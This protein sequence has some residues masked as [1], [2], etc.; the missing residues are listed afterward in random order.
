MP[1]QSRKHRGYRS[2]KVVAMYLAKHGFPFAESTGAGRSGTDI[3]GTIGIDW[4]V[5]ARKDFSPSTTIKQLKDRHNGKDLPVAVLRLNGQGEANVG[6]WVTLLRLE[7][8]VNLLHDAGYGDT[9]DE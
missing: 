8:F 3:T 6:E 4:E 7:D 2:Q 9:K 5:K 1:S